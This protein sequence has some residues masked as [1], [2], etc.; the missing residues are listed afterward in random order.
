MTHVVDTFEI[1]FRKSRGLPSVRILGIRPRSF[2]SFVGRILLTATLRSGQTS[3]L[4]TQAWPMIPS[5]MPWKWLGR[6]RCGLWQIAELGVQGK[7]F[8]EFP[9]R[10]FGCRPSITAIS[11]QA[12]DGPGE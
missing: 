8:R 3:V 9:E 10:I 7:Y 1:P 6:G 2:P 12:S 5:G 11:V 4:A